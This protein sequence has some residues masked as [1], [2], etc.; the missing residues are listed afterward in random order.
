MAG[1]VVWVPFE[2]V[3]A[4]YTLPLPQGSGCFQANSNGLASG[5]HRLEPIVHGL[6]EVIER[7]RPRSGG[8]GPTG[9]PWTRPA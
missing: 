4:N 5:N 3:S 7:T 9:A 8:C 6:C 1:G 2:L